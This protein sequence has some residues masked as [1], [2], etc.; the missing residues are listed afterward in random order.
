MK[1][2]LIAVF[3]PYHQGDAFKWTVP[4]YEAKL[5]EGGLPPDGARKW[6]GPIVLSLPSSSCPVCSGLKW[7]SG[8]FAT[9][10]A[11]P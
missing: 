2:P 3:R 7:I 1:D 9:R 8:A 11:P 5:I 6:A 10:S 4:D